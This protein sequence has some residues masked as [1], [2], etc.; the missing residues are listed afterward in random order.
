MSRPSFKLTSSQFRAVHALDKDIIVSAGAGSGKTLVLVGRY[1][2]LLKQKKAKPG[3]I[4]A[5]TYT[6]KAAQEMLTR[7]RTEIESCHELTRDAYWL[8]IKE[9][10]GRAPINTIHGFCASLLKEFPVEAGVD[11][12]FVVLE[13]LERRLLLEKTVDDVLA[14]RID[15]D[16]SLMRFFFRDNLPVLCGD[17]LDRK[18]QWNDI[19]HE[20]AA[21]MKA[22]L[23]GALSAL[24]DSV[25]NLLA[26][27]NRLKKSPTR[28][29]M[30]KLASKWPAYLS[31][32]HEIL[33]RDFAPELA[34]ILGELKLS[35][36]CPG[37]VNSLIRE[38]RDQADHFLS[39]YLAR[40]IPG[41]KRTILDL[42][43]KIRDRF[44][45]E[46]KC[47][48][49]LDFSDLLEHA[50]IMLKK[51]PEVRRRLAR[52]Y[53]YFLVDEFQDTDE[54]Q[55]SFID[56]LMDSRYG[57]GR[58]FVVGDP[59]Q[60]IYRF[61][62]A[63]VAVFNRMK[64]HII[65]NGGEYLT[66]NDNFRSCPALV[67][68]YNSLFGGLFARKYDFEPMEIRRSGESAGCAVE[69]LEYDAEDKKARQR[70][71]VEA[72][73][74][75]CRVREIVLKG[76]FPGAN[77]NLSWK[78]VVLLFS[79]MTNSSVYEKAFR[80]G[81]IPF[82]VVNGRG[83]YKQEEIIDVCNLLR[84]LSN[85]HDNTA[86][87]GLLRSPMFAVDDQTLLKLSPPA[88]SFSELKTISGEQSGLDENQ[89]ILWQRAVRILDELV[90]LRDKLTP[91]QLL[92][93][94]LQRTEYFSYLAYQPHG[95]AALANLEKLFSLMRQFNRKGLLSLHE[96]NLHLQELFWQENRESTA[97][98]DTEKSDLVRFMTI[99]QA[100]G[101]EFPVVFLPDLY[102]QKRQKLSE[103]AWH[104]QYGL[105]LSLRWGDARY[106]EET[107]KAIKNRD[108]QEDLEENQRLLY[109]AMTRAMEYLVL[110]V[111]TGPTSDEGA[112]GN[113]LQGQE[114]FQGCVKRKKGAAEKPVTPLPVEGIPENPAQPSLVAS[115]ASAMEASEKACFLSA[116]DIL[117][118]FFC[119]RRFYWQNIAGLIQ[120]SPLISDDTV[121]SPLNTGQLFHWLSAH[122]SYGNRGEADS[123]PEDY[124]AAG[125]GECWKN[126][127][128]AYDEISAARQPETHYFTEKE[129]IFK[130]DSLIIK[131]KWDYL[132]LSESEGTCYIADYKTA[133][134]EKLSPIHRELYRVQMD[135]YALAA[136]RLWPGYRIVTE[137]IYLRRLQ[138]EKKRYEPGEFEKIQASLKEVLNSVTG[139]HEAGEF[140]CHTENCAY[141]PIH[142]I[143][144]IDTNLQ[145]A[146]LL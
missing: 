129:F 73:V 99:H 92:V 119:P 45:A 118:Y 15:E 51:S 46:K 41:L 146:S 30:E 123:L 26:Q 86:L 102:F 91:A 25:E 22:D 142:N 79:A 24:V 1:L 138:R 32:L 29:A 109:V 12:Q 105:G 130:V 49:W 43:Q 68:A 139:N 13:E 31:N 74:I 117:N 85:L 88:W 125:I 8:E 37:I 48:G 40:I 95:D 83:F 77:R 70:R 36:Q 2:E 42:L 78:D 67:K 110:P 120:L 82:Y 69:Y 27:T 50:L 33:M 61:R 124:R 87:V 97:Q 4:V 52:K 72:N 140:P 19:P 38:V 80:D 63:D 107:Y 132:S 121:S 133:D 9:E 39:V 106:E 62:G 10:I 108:L 104:D 141:C 116:T 57:Q 114:A 111:L 14:K 28:T 137:I 84:V 126:F 144:R 112:W 136:W 60:S 71:A 47:H 20:P 66:M 131:G 58:L 64:E 16:G 5:I 94:G 89:L 56:L 3:E 7:L 127:R 128:T 17:L 98:L 59:K 76:L 23:A 96:L 18:L 100:K 122:Y 134:G 93:E 101:L 65:A 145:K 81:N 75:A 143:C 53:G 11:P 115:V 54:T 44:M 55:K 21:S 135:I 35:R 103:I 34:D 90:S 113:L 6:R